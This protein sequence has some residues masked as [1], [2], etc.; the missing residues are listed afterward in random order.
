M[1]MSYEGRR[2]E[3]RLSVDDGSSESFIDCQD[4]R[5]GFFYIVFLFV[6]DFSTEFPD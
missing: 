5:C 6:W 1:Q 4:R 2:L 3:I